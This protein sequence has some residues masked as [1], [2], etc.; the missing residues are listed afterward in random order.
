MVSYKFFSK[1]WNIIP[2]ALTSITAFE[3]WVVS[4]T[5]VS[6]TVVLLKVFCL[7]SLIWSFLF[8][9]N[10]IQFHYVYPAVDFLLLILLRVIN[11]YESGN[12]YLS[13]VMENFQILWLQLYVSPILSFLF[14][15]FYGTPLRIR[16]SFL[17]SLHISNT[18]LI[19][20]LCNLCNH[21]YIK[22]LCF[23]FQ[24]S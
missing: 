24:K 17:P 12:W 5:V 10:F 15:S 9:F 21:S 6:L 11:V 7:F 13:P 16:Y 18:V 20:Q 14:S 19:I 3:N 22:L 1:Q 8:M 4:L 2:Q 23:Y